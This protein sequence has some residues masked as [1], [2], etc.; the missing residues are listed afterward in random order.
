ML[1]LYLL[2]RVVSI[3]KLSARVHMLCVHKAECWSCVLLANLLCS[4][5]RTA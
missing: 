5:S 1:V 4:N 3:I 2:E